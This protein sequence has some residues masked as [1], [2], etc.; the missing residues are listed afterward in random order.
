[1]PVQGAHTTEEDWKLLEEWD[2]KNVSGAEVLK[3]FTETVYDEEKKLYNKILSIK[4]GT[5]SHNYKQCYFGFMSE[6][7]IE[8]L[9]NVATIYRNEKYFKK[10]EMQYKLF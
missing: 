2:E 8:V 4:Q 6:E 5:K 1:M 9:I 3:D 10:I 7:G